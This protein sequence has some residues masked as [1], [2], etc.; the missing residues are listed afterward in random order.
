MRCAANS[1]GVM[2][3][4][5]PTNDL[6]ALGDLGLGNLQETQCSILYVTSSCETFFQPLDMACTV[7]KYN[8]VFIRDR[9]SNDKAGEKYFNVIVGSNKIT[10]SGD[11]SPG[12]IYG[13]L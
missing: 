13:G 6:W 10:L 3:I 2:H 12:A 7:C 5:E 8:I 11:M 1:E 9:G 4:S